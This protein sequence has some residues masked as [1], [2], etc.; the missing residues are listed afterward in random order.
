M[1]IVI[2]GGGASGMAAALAAAE[3]PAA[4]VILLERQARVGRKLA[5]TGNG[6]VNRAHI[7]AAL[8][9]QGYTASVKEA[10]ARLLRP[11][12]GYYVPPRR[13]DVWEMIGYIRSI[14]AV[15]VLAHPFLNLTD[16]QLTAFLPEAKKLGLAGM[17]CFYS[18]YDAQTTHRSLEL[19]DAYGLLYS[20]GSDF[21]GAVKPDISLGW[22]KGDLR[23]PLSW[24]EAL[25]GAI[26]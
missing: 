6:Y 26:E 5:A 10:F 12:A 4:E 7:A 20:G 21:H 14:H 19:A 25:K 13:P 9:E 24:A 23:I 18:T 2:I 17:E 8:T 1:T 22:G 15:P 11:E 16:A 3:N